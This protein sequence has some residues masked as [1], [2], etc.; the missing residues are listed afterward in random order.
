MIYK[1]V[2]SS[3]TPEERLNLITKY[4]SIE[5][6]IFIY[7]IEFIMQNYNLDETTIKTII[8]DYSEL[9]LTVAECNLCN[10][11]FEVKLKSREQFYSIK[12]KDNRICE[13]CEVY[14]PYKTLLNTHSN[15][16]E[17]SVLEK[18]VLKGII[19]LKTKRLIYKHIF[20][21][22][23]YDKELWAT[24]NSLERKGYIRI[25]RTEDCKIKCFVGLD[26]GGIAY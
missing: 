17:I 19:H 26:K 8:N 15:S 13:L 16:N 14:S 20:N 23:L 4:W 7:N 21:N 9:I 3:E 25:E 2:L 24:V 1:I 5:N 22:N 11:G 6:D 10:S 12:D 18:Y